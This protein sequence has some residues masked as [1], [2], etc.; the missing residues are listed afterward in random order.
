MRVL[1]LNGSPNQ[2][3]CT[4]TALS[5]VAKTLHENG[6]ETEF[7]HLGKKAVRGCIGCRKCRENGSQRCIYT[8]DIANEISERLQAADGLV[9]GS[10]VYYAGPNGALLAVLD[11]AFYSAGGT[12]KGKA[13]A[14]VVS[15]RRGGT[16]AA[17]DC[18][19]KYF[20]ISQ[21]PQVSSQYWHMVHGN[22]P[23]EVAQDEEGLQTMRT[24]GRNMAWQL[25]G[26]HQAG[27]LPEN[28]EK[29]LRTNFIR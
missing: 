22:T 19:Q 17:L 3:G 16:T 25:K 27:E 6:V 28:P 21:M 8:D 13:A 26:L 24:L 9:V 20:T 4:F 12:F 2:A 18:L 29:P 11:R 1:L 10:P 7:L 14:A 5:E 23:Q 15:A